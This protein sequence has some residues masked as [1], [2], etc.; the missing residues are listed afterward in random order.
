M[1]WLRTAII[2]V[3]MLSAF[4]GG[5]GQTKTVTGET[6]K[7]DGTAP[8]RSAA[9]DSLTVEPYQ[10]GTG[11]SAFTEKIDENPLDTAYE[12]ERQNAV[13]TQDFCAVEEKYAQLWQAELQRSLD[14]LYGY[15]TADDKAKLAKQQENWAAFALSETAVNKEI[16]E[17]DGYAVRLGS[18]SAYRFLSERHALIRE[19]TVKIK[20]LTYLLET[21]TENPTA[22][23]KQMWSQFG[24]AM[25]EKVLADG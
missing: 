11:T 18:A 24:S 9:A 16:L 19:R 6:A 22:A 14:D 20:Y 8:T 5:C 13:T 23:E 2:C 7:T 15:L 25:S 17:N 3:C 21:Q 12:K 1:K 10:I 4:L